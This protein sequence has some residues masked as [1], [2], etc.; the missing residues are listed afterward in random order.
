MCCVKPHLNV[1]QHQLHLSMAQHLIL[2]QALVDG[3]EIVGDRW[4]LLILKVAFQGTSRFEGF[5]TKTGISRVTLNRRLRLLV[6]AGLFYKKPYGA[7]S[8]RFDYL[9]TKKALGLL[10]ASLLARQWELDW[11]TEGHDQLLQSEIVHRTC[12]HPFEAKAICKACSEELRFE[13]VRWP[14]FSANINFQLELMRS[15]TGSHR[16]RF[17]A[18]GNV[19]LSDLIGDRWSL[20]I[21]I[22]AFLGAKRY[23]H[24][25]KQLGIPPNILAARLKYLVANKILERE[26]YQSN[27]PRS[28]YLL[29]LKGRALFP[30]VLSLREWVIRNQ[31]EDKDELADLIHSSCGQPLTIQVACKTC[32]EA[33]KAK[34]LIIS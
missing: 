15:N 4:V 33:V 1:G 8:N 25:L 19:G 24:F 16:K 29:T 32:G 11:Q 31:I 26:L 34:D 20:A 23:D 28:Y 10:S 5:K 18:K 12:G 17:R 21:L 27:P 13:D 9:L 2:N 14:E 30:F 3:L 22:A 7:G 6:S